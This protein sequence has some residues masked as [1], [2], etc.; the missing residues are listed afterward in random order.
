ML[1]RAPSYY[2][3]APATHELAM[4]LRALD[5][6]EE[7]THEILRRQYLLQTHWLA[8][9]SLEAPDELHTF[10]IESVR[11]L[12]PEGFD[13][14]K[15]LT[16]RYRPWQQRIAIVPDGD[17]FAALREGK[18]SIVTDTIETFTENGIKVS[19]GEEIPAGIV[20]TA[21]G[22]NMSVLGDVEFTVD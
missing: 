15:H 8:R 18:A 17:L 10:L 11:P 9:T 20:V 3:A 12:L 4:T 7:W 16:P 6:P 5:I 1:Q 21:T 22:F 19:S 2:Y 13:V 14:D